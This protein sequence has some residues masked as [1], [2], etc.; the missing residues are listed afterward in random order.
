MEEPANLGVE[1]RRTYYRRKGQTELHLFALAATALLILGSMAAV[2]TYEMGLQQQIPATPIEVLTPIQQ[3][4][5]HIKHVVVVMME[6]HPYDTDYG[7]YCL[8]T[9]PYCPDAGNGLPSNT[10]VRLYP[11]SKTNLTCE[12]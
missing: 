7:T 12:K 9:G 1:P 2:A 10:C 5:S 8:V 4:T 11:N 6:N 3:F